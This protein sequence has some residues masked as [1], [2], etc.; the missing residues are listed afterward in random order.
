[1]TDWLDILAARREQLR[2]DIEYR[3]WLNSHP[4]LWPEGDDDNGTG[5][6]PEPREYYNDKGVLVYVG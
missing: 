4:E 1:M 2:L 5:P 6:R 3:E